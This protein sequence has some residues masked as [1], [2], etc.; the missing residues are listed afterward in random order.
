MTWWLKSFAN[1][2]IGPRRI[3]APAVVRLIVAFDC[4]GKLLDIT[5]VKCKILPD[6]EVPR[7]PRSLLPLS[8]VGKTCRQLDF[9][10]KYDY[11]IQLWLTLQCIVSFTDNLIYMNII[12]QASEILSY[13]PLQLVMVI[14]CIPIFYQYINSTGFNTT[15]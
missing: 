14:N 1:T 13:Q 8:D 11:I 7:S 10:K 3:H 6:V 12:H 2:K 9:Q 15:Y 5:L 4:N